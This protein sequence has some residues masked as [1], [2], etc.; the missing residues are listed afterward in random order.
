MRVLV[1]YALADSSTGEIAEQ[2][3]R[4]C[5]SVASR[6]SCSRTRQVDEIEGFDAIVVGTPSAHR[7][8]SSAT[9]PHSSTVAARSLAD[10]PLDFSVG[11]PDALPRVA[12]EDRTHR[13]DL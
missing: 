6:W 9:P 13:G 5:P 10:D 3:A 8:M 7:P 12:V 11:M 4:A 2:S 1:A